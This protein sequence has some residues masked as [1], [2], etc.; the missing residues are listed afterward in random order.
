MKVGAIHYSLINLFD[1]MLLI[2][3]LIKVSLKSDYTLDRLGESKIGS[4]DII[5]KKLMTH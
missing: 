3:F 2:L 4:K 5:K 1:S